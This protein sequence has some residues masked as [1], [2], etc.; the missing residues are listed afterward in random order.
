MP[1]IGKLATKA[2]TA[3][4]AITGSGIAHQEASFFLGVSGSA[5]STIGGHCE[6]S[7]WNLL[8][9]EFHLQRVRFSNIY[10]NYIVML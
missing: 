6:Q 5:S 2:R 4:E 8:Q 7:A 10:S 9:V 3:A 1:R